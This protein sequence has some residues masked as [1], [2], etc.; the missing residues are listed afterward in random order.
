MDTE[1]IAS[2]STTTAIKGP[3]EQLVIIF[4]VDEGKN[5]EKDLC[6]LLTSVFR[7]SFQCCGVNTDPV[8]LERQQIG[9]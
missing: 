9:S 1:S 8:K 6:N 7:N 5:N 2:S 4:H 3:D